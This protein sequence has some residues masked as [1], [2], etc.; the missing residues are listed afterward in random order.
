VL[1]PNF[2]I[3]FGG[4]FKKF[5]ARAGESDIEKFAIDSQAFAVDFGR[6]T[7]TPATVGEP[8]GVLFENGDPSEVRSFDRGRRN[9]LRGFRGTRPV[10][11]DMRDRS[12]TAI[13]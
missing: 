5:S 1:I 12:T 6:T 2:A 9:G 4:P 7:R 13:L 3:N 11:P 10:P 8:A